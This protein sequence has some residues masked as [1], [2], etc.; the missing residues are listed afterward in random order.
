VA[1][2]FKDGNRSAKGERQEILGP[3]FPAAQQDKTVDWPDGTAPYLL[4]Q[5]KEA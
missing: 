4:A 3:Q 1:G 2:L 5:K